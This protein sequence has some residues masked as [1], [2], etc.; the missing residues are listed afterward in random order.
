MNPIIFPKDTWFLVFQKL[1]AEDLARSRRVCTLF[2]HCI[3][4]PRLNLHWKN[5]LLKRIKREAIRSYRLPKE[6]YLP[7]VNWMMA[8]YKRAQLMYDRKNLLVRVKKR[9]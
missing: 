7:D 9:V 1:P 5:E 2:H 8:Y 3:G 6:F 4:D